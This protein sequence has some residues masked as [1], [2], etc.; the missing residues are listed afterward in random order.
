MSTIY[1]AVNYIRATATSEKDKGTKF[2]RLTRFFLKNDPLWKSRFSDVWLWANSPTN[3][4]VDLGI[5]L[6]A[7]DSKDG[8]YWAIQCKCQDDDS[9]LD[10]REV[11]TFY[12]KTGNK[13]QYPNN[14]IVTTAARYSKHL[15]TIASQWDT[16]RIFADDMAASELDYTDWIDGKAVALRPLK[17]PRPHQKEAISECLQKFMTYDRGKLIM[18][19]GTGKTL[20]S[21]RLTEELF[22]SQNQPGG[23]VLFLAPSIALVGQS[24]REWANQSKLPM[25]CAVVCSDAK[26]SNIDEDTWESSLKDLPY[27]ASTDPEAL[28]S[29]ME[30]VDP[31]SLAVV[32]S[33]Y[34]SIQVVANAQKMG[35]PAFD[36]I[37]CDEAHRTTGMEALGKQE[38][39][40]EYIKVHNNSIINGK[41]RLYM[42]A[43]PRIYGDRAIRIANADSY[44]V[45][46]M[47]D[48]SVYGPEFYRLS[49]GRAIDE[50]LLSDYKVIT[51]SV[52]EDIVSETYQRAQVEEGEGFDVN[53]S[54]RIVGC[55]KGLL[56][57]G[58]DGGHRLKN[59][60]VFCNTIAESK[61]MSEHF[62]RTVDAYIDYEK[63]Q[64]KPLPD[65]RCEIEHIDGTMDSK[66]RRERL[67]WLEQ[68]ETG[69]DAA[70]HILSNARCLAEG[71]DVPSLDAVIFLMPKK[72]QIDI[73]QA[74]GRVMRKFEGKEFGYIILPIVIPAGITAD[75]ALENHDT[76][77]VVWE[78]LKALRSHD[79]RLD[80]RINALPYDKGKAAPVVTAVDTSDSNPRPV[81]PEEPVENG[82]EEEQQLEMEGYKSSAS[83]QLQE[84]INALIVKK[85]GTK[86]YWDIWAKDIAEI[87]KRHIQ[88]IGE[89]IREDEGARSEFGKFLRGLKDSLNDSITEDQA[90]EMLAQHI[91]T[92]PV[93]KALFAGTGFAESNP[94]SIAMEGMLNTLRRFTLETEAEERELRELYASVRMRAE[95]IRTDAGRQSVIKD[96]YE[97]F[98]KEAFKA[99]SEKMGIVYTPNQIVDYILHATDRLL[100]KEFGQHLCDQGV[101][102]LDAFTGTGT[103][104]VDL[105]NDKELMP[106]E[107][108]PYK[109]RNEIHCNEIMLLAYYIAS[110]NIEHA[111]HSRVGGDYESFPGAVLTDTFQM[112]EENDSLDV[113]MFI[114]NSE[115]ILRQMEKD[116]KVLIGNPPWSAKQ[117]SANDNN[118]NESYPTLDKRIS[119]TYAARTQATNKNAL[120]DS[121]IRAFRWASDRINEKGIISFVTNGGW[122]RGDSANGFRRCL[123]EEF[124]SIYIFDLRGN[125][126]ISGEERRKEKDNVFG[127]GTRTPV[128]ITILVKNPDSH[129]KGIIYYHD[130][131]DY[132][133]RDEKLS[134]ISSAAS[135]K[136][137]TWSTIIPD[138]Y[139]DWLDQRNDS[140]YEF[141]PIGIDNKIPSERNGVFSCF[142][143]GTETDRDTWVYNYSLSCLEQNVKKTIVFYDAERKRWQ[144]EY[145]EIAI[146]DFLTYDTSCVS[147]TRTLRN[148]VKSNTII[149][150]HNQA[151]RTT[152]YR[153]FC[154]THSYMD[155]GLV[156]YPG[157]MNEFFPGGKTYKNYAIVTPGKGNNKYGCLIVDDLV[158]VNCMSAGAQCFPLYWYEKAVSGRMVRHDAIT[159]EALCF[160]RKA[161]PGGIVGRLMKDGG[162]EIQKEDIFYYIYG[163]LHSEEYRSRFSANLKKG[164]PRIPLAEHFDSFYYAGKALAELH[165]NY[166][167]AAPY[168]LTVIG[169]AAE[170]GPVEKMR[171][172]KKRNPSTGKLE[173]DKS[174]LVYN[175]NLTFR[176]I[177]DMAHRYVVNGR[178]PLEWVIDRYQIKTDPASGIVNDPNT[179]SDDPLYIAN[180]VRRLVAVSVETIK[181]VDSLTRIN[182]KD[183]YADFPEVWKAQK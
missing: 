96:L 4:G 167:S 77:A 115:R 174:V 37:I 175:R 145:A 55:W 71:V 168:P 69:E 121:Y 79:E 110:I 63:E 170:P 114:E 72:S 100:Y 36:L 126:L 73:I 171:W 80:A 97:S 21:L 20:T 169:N 165:L 78:V 54:A 74:V 177:P 178:S 40:S 86:V 85:C 32:F 92:L 136:R 60:V 149:R 47:D 50:N 2:E 155:R 76:Y 1:E 150:F 156:D 139:G 162:P 179:Y 88:R 138:K 130:I 75:Q 141:I 146:E 181:I 137:F 161:Y 94:V 67:R 107:K 109:Y 163:I 68:T 152:V 153:P 118:A 53:E 183:C 13:G 99:T 65:F 58:E 159:D 38:E 91:I 26:A 29:Q 6:V 103:F 127:Q 64:G 23:R 16:I 132:L 131:G 84:A 148:K 147:W 41:K 166:E 95:G 42:T 134:I 24:M 90:V 116:I 66:M 11:A 59:A 8:T 19:C 133:T 151:F 101:H 143:R 49:F 17:E 87:A 112:H 105:I 89:I 57:Q 10:Y 7:Q 102:I 39:A 61:H 122:L 125:A 173:A 158:D 15:D 142:S 56:N 25:V 31:N 12:G 51:L 144:S 82:N 124:D 182:E 46:S 164:L 180:L 62:Q 123:A 98:F 33:T 30:E 176:D 5:D 44:V 113:D 3:D 70:C 106:D 120:Y 157:Q 52:P 119:E 117:T 81:P 104:I 140:W 93:F 160:F 22:H 9:S 35:L 34:Q 45:S 43:T 154:K 129:K 28:F 135:D 18:A 48:E 14:M 128:I 111:Y 172:G 83:K 108:L 27:P